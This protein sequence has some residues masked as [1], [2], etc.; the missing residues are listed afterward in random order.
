MFQFLKKLPCCPDLIIPG[1]SCN[2]THKSC[3]IIIRPT[4]DEGPGSNFLGTNSD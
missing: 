2:Y 3:V 1:S 4:L